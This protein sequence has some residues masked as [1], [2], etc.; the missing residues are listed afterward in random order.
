MPDIRCLKINAKK[1]EL[2]ID[3]YVAAFLLQAD[4]GT[5][6]LSG[7]GS[8]NIELKSTLTDGSIFAG[9]TFEE[10]WGAAVTD[11]LNA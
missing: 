5:W 9:G 3:G 8:S 10:A 6:H 1:Y 11:Y 7:V 4:E 2:V